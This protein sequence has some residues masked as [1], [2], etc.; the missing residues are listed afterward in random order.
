[1]GSLDFWEL[2]PVAPGTV[3]VGEGKRKIGNGQVKK[4][5]HVGIAVAKIP[6][7]HGSSRSVLQLILN[8]TA[9]PRC[10]P[11]SRSALRTRLESSAVAC[12]PGMDVLQAGDTHQGGSSRSSPRSAT[13]DQKYQTQ[14]QSVDGISELEPSPTSEA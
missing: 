10:P 2:G 7:P 11:Y 5:I 9:Q 3:R 4:E 14:T 6:S 12:E 1:M 8:G 13:T